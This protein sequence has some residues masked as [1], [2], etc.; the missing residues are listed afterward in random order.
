MDALIALM[1]ELEE[2]KTW[3]KYMGNVLWSA[4][5]VAYN[6]YP[7]PIY[8]EFIRNEPKDTRTGREIISDL[9]AMLSEGGEA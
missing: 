8:T 2:E 9:I 7:Y 3:R 6:E 4:A 5:R 1:S